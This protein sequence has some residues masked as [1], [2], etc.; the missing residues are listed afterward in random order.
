MAL[1]VIA[2]VIRAVPNG[3]LQN[4]RQWAYVLHYRKTGAITYAAAIALLDPLL[5]GVFNAAIGA[6]F[7]LKNT[8]VLA[9]SLQSIKYTPLDGSTA[10]T[11]TPHVLAG[12]Q[13]GDAL[14]ANV[15]LVVTHRTA[16]RGR[17]YR[18]RTYLAAFGEGVNDATGVP[19]AA[20]A[21]GINV[22]F[23]G[24]LAALVGT[25]L[26]MVVA[27][28]LHSTA[29]NVI[30]CTVNSVWDTQRRRLQ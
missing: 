13:A 21:T 24:H 29:E 9:S 30:A 18:G 22:Q 28:Y 12:V 5:Y 4:G 20:T 25:G 2:D 17:S 11:V 15:S 14:P 19:S 23:T 3:L 27:S 26:T 8:M 10:T 6:G 16:L 7:P 1:P